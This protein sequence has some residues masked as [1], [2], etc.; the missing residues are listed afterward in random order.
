MRLRKRVKAWLS[1]HNNSFL[2]QH[3]H[4]YQLIPAPRGNT[5]HLQHRARFEWKLIQS[6]KENRFQAGLRAYLVAYWE[7]KTKLVTNNSYGGKEAEHSFPKLGQVSQQLWKWKRSLIISNDVLPGRVLCTGAAML[8]SCRCSIVSVWKRRKVDPE[9]K[10]IQMPTPA[11][12]MW[13][14]TMPSSWWASNC[15]C[16]VGTGHTVLLPG[17]YYLHKAFTHVK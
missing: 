3:L 6:E 7:S 1:C 10:A 12:T 9:L 16:R 2:E 15:L 11:T 17:N 4:W 14:T 13:D 5:S 8:M